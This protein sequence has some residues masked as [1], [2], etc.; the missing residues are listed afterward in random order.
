[1]HIQCVGKDGNIDKK[2]HK[3][4]TCR[5]KRLIFSFAPLITII[6]LELE[7]SSITSKITWYYVDAVL[8]TFASIHLK[9]L[10]H[11]IY[12][13]TETSKRTFFRSSKNGHFHRLHKHLRS[14]AIFIKIS[15]FL[16]LSISS[17]IFHSF[18]SIFDLW[19]HKFPRLVC[20]H[21]HIH[22]TQL[23]FYV[24]AWQ[25]AN[26]NC[27]FRWRTNTY[28]IHFRQLQIQIQYFGCVM[29]IQY[30]FKTF[31]DKS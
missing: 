18:T 13:R 29:I 6:L 16:R 26:W 8:K 27:V 21:L 1:M 30:D 22:W 14:L 28:S 4:L 15:L 12:I 23:I 25:I 10:G 11:N 9:L 17:F 7:L 3:C 2:F 31:L 19:M 5:Y 24:Y 20:S